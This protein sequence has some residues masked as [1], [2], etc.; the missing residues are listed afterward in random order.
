MRIATWNL[1]RGGRTRAARGAQE[2]VLRG[3]GADV[4]ALTEPPS[5][6]RE[7][8]GVVTSPPRRAGPSGVESWAAVVGTTVERIP[9]EIPFQRMAVA[10]RAG[11]EERSVIIYCAVL[12]WLSI[13]SHAPELVRHGEDS[14][15]VFE[16]VLGEQVADIAELRRSHA[17]PVIWAGDF[18]QSLAGPTSGGSEARRSLLRDALA[19]LGYAAWNG[20][21]AH[22]SAGMCAVDL[23]C[24]REEEGIE[25]QGRIDP[26]HGD[27]VMSDHAG[28]WVDIYGERPRMTPSPLLG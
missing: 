8:A 4:V 27:I 9:I 20:I 14:F 22:A 24:G 21:A 23:I 28:Y 3:L 16:R 17:M 25:A 7:A 6:Y 15:T 2:D 11:R 1:E 10:A 19:S 13:T 18:N 12:P 5:S 26:R